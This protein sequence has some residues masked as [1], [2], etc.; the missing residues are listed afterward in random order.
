MNIKGKMHFI[1]DVQNVTDKF[2]KR[3]FVIEF[4]ET[5]PDYKE[6][7]KLECQKD[8]VEILDNLSI[9]DEVSVD[10]NLRGRPWTNKSGETTYFNTLVAWRVSK[11]DSGQELAYFDAEKTNSLEIEDLPF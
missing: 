10:F 5:N 11:E 7:I 6:Y 9:G 3:D 8:R 1:G 2:K 4:S